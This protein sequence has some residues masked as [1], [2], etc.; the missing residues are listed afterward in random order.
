L[1]VKGIKK[2]HSSIEKF[3]LGIKKC[4]STMMLPDPPL[5]GP[6]SIRSEVTRHMG[7]PFPFFLITSS[8]PHFWP[9]WFKGGEVGLE[10]AGNSCLVAQE[11]I[12]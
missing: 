2:C 8:P 10:G 4:H 12:S 7:L 1:V 5:A 11:V 3:H 6:D 9:F